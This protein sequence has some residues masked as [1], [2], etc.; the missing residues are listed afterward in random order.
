[1]SRYSVPDGAWDAHMH[2]TDL[3]Q[4][5]T[6]K[7]GKANYKPHSSTLDEA[8]QSAKRLSIPNLAFTQTSTYGLDNSC[9]LW[10]LKQVTP[11]HGR[12]V[13]VIDPDTVTQKQ[14]EDW[15]ASGVRGVRINL[16]SIG[17]EPS[18]EDL[19][20]LLKSVDA[21]IAPMK[22]WAIHVYAD[23]AYMEVLQTIVGDLQSKICIDHMGSPEKGMPGSQ[24]CES[25]SWKALKSMLVRDNV[26]V[27]IS[28][29]YRFHETGDWSQLEQPVRELLACREGRGGVFASDWP[30]TRFESTDIK[31]WVD[32][33]LDW[34]GS[35][36]ALRLRLFRENAEELYDV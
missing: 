11:S 30:H 9:L 5:P 27:K 7:A 12:G 35:D 3:D 13:V 26:F 34:C 16:K 19:R 33:C 8:R 4:F 21:V 10:C 36:D 24:I 23:M 32:L 25:P 18:A 2:V 14:L 6:E 29:P 28:A 1:M 22:T 17:A 15:H 31:P 20:S